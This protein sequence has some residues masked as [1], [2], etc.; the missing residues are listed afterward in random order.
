MLWLEIPINLIVVLF[1][2]SVAGLMIVIMMWTR[3][4]LRRNP[5]LLEQIGHEG[6]GQAI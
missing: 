4:N 2:L 5:A 1:G 3:R 6:Y